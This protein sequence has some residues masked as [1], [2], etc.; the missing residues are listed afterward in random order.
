MKLLLVEADPFV[1]AWLKKVLDIAGFDVDVAVGTT[2]G[3]ASTVARARYPI[4]MIGPQTPASDRA[5]LVRLFYA[6]PDRAAP[7]LWVAPF[8][9]DRDGAMTSSPG[10]YFRDALQ[11]EALATRLRALLML[12]RDDLG[13]VL[14]AGNVTLD[15]AAR[16]VVVDKKVTFFPSAEVVVLAML[17]QHEGQVVP[18]KLIEIRL[19]GT[20]DKRAKNAVEVCIHR[21]RKRLAT[22]AASVRVRTIHRVGYFI[23]E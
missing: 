23:S 8:N 2:D 18:K 5:K 7:L 4:V 17:M 22:A 15:T 6:Q 12:K 10:A 19:W 20:T 3:M 13:A 21:L 9:G 11:V 14:R 16:Q 1:S